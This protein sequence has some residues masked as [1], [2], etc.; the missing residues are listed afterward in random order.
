MSTNTSNV[1][2][3]GGKLS[4]HFSVSEFSC[5]CG[6][7][8]SSV[9]PRLIDALEALRTAAQLR[10]ITI[11]SGCR[12][13]EHNAKSGGAP[14]SFHLPPV[15][16]AADIRVNGMSTHRLYELAKRVPAL[17]GFGIAAGFLHVDVRDKRALWYYPGA[18]KL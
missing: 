13:P 17:K 2:G 5:R 15:C 14:W 1:S 8:F 10:P 16:R 18:K 9:D 11:L 6:C 4:P 7:G 3:G 12:C